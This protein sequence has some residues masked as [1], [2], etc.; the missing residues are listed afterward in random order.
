[1]RKKGAANL[2]NALSVGKPSALRKKRK[3]RRNK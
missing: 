2:R 1:M 3:P